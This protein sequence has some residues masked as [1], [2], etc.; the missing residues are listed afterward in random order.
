MQLLAPA[1][2]E[3]STAGARC[4]K[5][6]EATREESAR[7]IPAQFQADAAIVDPPGHG[8]TSVVLSRE[9]WT[10][11]APEVDVQ[12][13]AQPSQPSHA[14]RLKLTVPAKCCQYHSVSFWRT[15]HMHNLATES[16]SPNTTSRPFH[17]HSC[18][19]PCARRSTD[20][21]WRCLWQKRRVAGPAGPDVPAV[22]RLLRVPRGTGS[23]PPSAAWKVH[24]KV[25]GPVVTAVTSCANYKQMGWYDGR[26]HSVPPSLFDIEQAGTSLHGCVAPR[27]AST[28][29]TRRYPCLDQLPEGGCCERYHHVSPGT[30]VLTEPESARRHTSGAVSRQ[31]G[32]ATPT[33]LGTG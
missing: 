33:N 2:V 18:K 16:T 22:H 31:S 28:V 29:R 9:Q 6:C 1:A 10:F 32:C 5:P 7:E 26:S 20:L 15:Q 12:G 11:H 13:S 14:A 19:S 3:V 21:W 17:T 23:P 24:R 27:G 25:G 30:A 8:K 4:D